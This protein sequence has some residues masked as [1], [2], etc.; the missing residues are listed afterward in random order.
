MVHLY[1]NTDTVTTWKI[2]HFIRSDRSDL[3]MIH[4]LSIAFIWYMLTCLS[5]DEILGL[6]YGNWSTDFRELPL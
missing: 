2:S 6:R 3:H 4:N 1:S 5:L